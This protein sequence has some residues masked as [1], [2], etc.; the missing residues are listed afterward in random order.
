MALTLQGDGTLS[1]GTMLTYVHHFRYVV[2]YIA[3]RDSHPASELPMSTYL[4]NKSSQYRH[5]GKKSE[6]D[7]S[8][9]VMEGKHQWIHWYVCTYCARSHVG[10]LGTPRSNQTIAQEYASSGGLGSYPPMGIDFR[11]SVTDSATI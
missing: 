7:K 10:S 5:L 2:N 8:W 9:Q 6:S 11:P 4:T 1:E 3:V